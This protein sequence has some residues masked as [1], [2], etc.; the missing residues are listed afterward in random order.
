MKY[1]YLNAGCGA[2]WHPEWINLDVQASSRDVIRCDVRRGT[3]Y[4][5]GYFDAVYHSHLLEHLSREEG[6]KFVV[7]CARVL[8]KDGILRVVVPDLESIAKE[9]LKQLRGALKGNADAQK[10]YEWIYLE[11]YDQATRTVSG[12]DM[13]VYLRKKYLPNKDYIKKRLGLAADQYFFKNPDEQ[14]NFFP[15]IA[16]IFKE[17]LFR[18]TGEIHKKMYDKYSL[19]TLLLSSGFYNVV[20][21]SAVTS[22]IARFNT[23]QLD[24]FGGEVRKADSLFMEA[25]RK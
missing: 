24:S 13:E 16:R 7:E 20:R 2:V 21:M 9:Y 15:G 18:N 1:K 3:P 17:V 8:K 12:G 19:K 14:T 25:R 4:P 6:E 10:N 22:H 5:D 11:L 23:Y